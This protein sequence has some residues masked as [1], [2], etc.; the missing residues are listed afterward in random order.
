[1]TAS[2]LVALVRHLRPPFLEDLAT[3]EITA[4]LAGARLRRFLKNSV[5]TNQGHPANHIFMVLAG[6]V[7]SFF[8]TEGGQKLYIHWY[9]PGDMFGGMALVSRPSV[10]LLS[11]EALKNSSTLVWERATIRILAAQH[12]KLLDNALSIA[13][14]YLNLSIATR[15]SL[16][17]HTARQRLAV[18][19]ANLAS[20]IGHEVPGGIELSVRNDE[21]AAAA[22]ITLFTAS[23]IMS[24]WERRKIVKK[25][26]GKVVVRSPEQL[27]L[28]EI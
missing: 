4:I 19:L 14:N 23:R 27:L 15:V 18:V 17:C 12:P 13:S 1:M 21:L 26:R 9:P 16:S 8:L 6:A 11:S 2:E 10:Y 22:N 28:Q 5:I 20:G 3:P 7:Q 25:T 24:E